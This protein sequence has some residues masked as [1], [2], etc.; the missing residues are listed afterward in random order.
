MDRDTARVEL[1]DRLKRAGYRFV[2]VTP[3]THAR[4]IA[5]QQ[6]GP[7]DLRD[8]FGWNRVFEPGDLDSELLALMERGGMLA[9]EGDRLR[10]GLRVASLGTDLFLHSA[11]PT[12][13]ADAVFFGPDTYRFARFIAANLEPNFAGHL[14]D[15]GAGSGAGGIAAARLAPR[16]RATL[17]D[18]NAAALELAAVNAR[19]AGIGVKCVQA[20]VLPGGA[21]LV[22]ANPPYMMDE[23]ARTYR[24]GGD[25]AGGAVALAWVRDALARLSP[26]GVVLLYTGAA[27][28]D[29]QSPL[30]EALGE[31]C[32]GAGAGLHVEELDPDVFGEEL[33][34]PAYAGVERIAVIGAI[35]R[36]RG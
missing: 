16:A 7:P 27:L 17:V 8:V 31:T 28:V 30:I 36:T 25:M 26:D 4:V 1:L 22:I 24:D 11:Y 34:R 29:G 33:E 5:R 14:I 20:D 32:R 15:M 12:E 6:A 9:A 18:S 10:S 35:I 23:G 21:D 3:A 19:A 13:S 2:T